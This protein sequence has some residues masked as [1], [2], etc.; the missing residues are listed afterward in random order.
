MAG[1][2]VG[3]GDAGERHSLERTWGR[4]K[5]RQGGGEG[6]HSISGEVNTGLGRSGAGEERPRKQEA[7]AST[8]PLGGACPG[9]PGVPNSSRGTAR[10]QLSLH[11]ECVARTCRMMVRTAP[12]APFD[13]GSHQSHPK[14]SDFSHW[15]P[16]P[17]PASG[18]MIPPSLPLVPH[19]YHHHHPSHWPRRP[20]DTPNCS[21]RAWGDGEQDL[22][23]ASKP[24]TY[25]PTFST[26]LAQKEPFGHA[27]A[28][29]WLLPLAFSGQRSGR[30]LTILERTG[31]CP[32]QGII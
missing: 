23:E 15:H 2:Q 26:I 18:L 4:R 12:N 24:I 25:K 5:G 19:C 21:P 32:Q 27:W 16:S 9:P 28:H 14:S 3:P 22:S 17:P 30:L 29:F 10:S 6:R 31:Q 8:S 7:R 13:L 11:D 20:P 1:E